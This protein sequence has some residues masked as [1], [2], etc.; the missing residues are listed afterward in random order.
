MISQRRRKKTATYRMWLTR[1]KD[2]K[3]KPKEEKKGSHLSLP[4]FMP[5]I[6]E[7]PK[8]DEPKEKDKRK[9]D[10]DKGRDKRRSR[11]RSNER[12][13]IRSKRTHESNWKKRD[14]SKD[15]RSMMLSRNWQ[16][17]SLKERGE[18]GNKR[19]EKAGAT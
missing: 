17:P 14:H 12:H 6:K 15:H 2:E 19:G 5:P 8:K 16:I 1:I 9:G 4:K 11:S 13:I 7:E 3:E 18:R 10:E